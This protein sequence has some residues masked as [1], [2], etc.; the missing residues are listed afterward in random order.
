MTK[1]I[2]EVLDPRVIKLNLEAEDKL[3]AITQLAEILNDADYI[4]D[5][6]SFVKDIYVRESEGITGIG[7]GIAIPHGKSNY[8]TNVGVAIGILNHPIKW[9][10][11]D[12][13]PVNII[14]L[15]AVSNDVE[16]A[17]NQLRLLS[18]FAGQLGHDKVIEELQSAQS[19]DDVISIFTQKEG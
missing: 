19:V 14:I 12:D 8:V 11:L 3:D 15:F 13:K 1:Q 4:D 18:M 5:V 9:E 2:S 16:S 17:K 6:S 10:T 7:D